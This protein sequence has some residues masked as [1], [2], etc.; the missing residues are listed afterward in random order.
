MKT[1]PCYI[2]RFFVE[3]GPFEPA[4]MLSFNDRGL[5][6]DSDY[7][8]PVESDAWVTRSEWFEAAPVAPVV[9]KP[10]AKKAAATTVTAAKAPAAKRAKKSA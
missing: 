7:I 1:S 10:A 5:I 8:R 3:F 2:S 9:A 4:E 6:Q